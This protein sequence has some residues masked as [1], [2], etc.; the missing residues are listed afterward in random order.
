ML[1]TTQAGILVSSD[2]IAYVA[3]RH[4][5]SSSSP[6]PGEAPRTFRVLLALDISEGAFVVA[7]RELS[8]SQAL[9]VREDIAQHWETGA[10]RWKAKD[11]LAR[12]AQ[13]AYFA[14]DG[15]S[16]TLEILSEAKA[17]EMKEVEASEVTE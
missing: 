9:F 17:E 6:L 15:T 1:L 14:E 13:G 16:E 7:A 12:H 5:E 2:R 4:E 8:A 10:R 11:S 3:L